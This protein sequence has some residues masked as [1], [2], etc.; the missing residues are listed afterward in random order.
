MPRFAPFWLAHYKEIG[1]CCMTEPLKKLKAHDN[2][3][4]AIPEKFQS[5]QLVVDYID[6]NWM[7]G[8]G[9]KWIG[10][11]VQGYYAWTDPN[12]MLYRISDLQRNE[13]GKEYEKDVEEVEAYGDPRELQ[14]NP[15]AKD[16]YTFERDMQKNCGFCPGGGGSSD[17]DIQEKEGT[18]KKNI[19]DEINLDELMKGQMN[20]FIPDDGSYVP[21]PMEY[22]PV[23]DST[24]ITETGHVTGEIFGSFGGD[25]YTPIIDEFLPG[26]PNQGNGTDDGSAIEK[27]AIYP[28]PYLP[29]KP[30]PTPTPN[31]TP[32]GKRGLPDLPKN[33]T[34]TRP[35]VKIDPAIYLPP[36]AVAGNPP[37]VGTYPVTPTG[38]KPPLPP[39]KLATIPKIIPPK[40]PTQSIPKAGNNK[41]AERVKEAEEM[42]KNDT[43]TYGRGKGKIDC[44]GATDEISKKVKDGAFDKMK[45]NPNFAPSLAANQAE[46]LKETGEFTTNINNV[47]EGDYIFWTKDDHPTIQKIGHTGIVTSIVNGKITVATAEQANLTDKSFRLTVLAEDGTIW[48]KRSGTGG[49]KFV[50]AGRP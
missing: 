27:V 33:P 15:T 46:H 16:L 23:T 49:Q 40:K 10:W 43:R 28:I 18:K 1:N 45:Y 3:K 34:D 24:E 44:S 25:S 20:G 38:R 47:K 13:E 37:S 22:V 29:P 21:K 17:D 6:T 42:V 41:A 26:S 32:P 2:E 14:G 12:G 35:A 5:L 8:K 30:L 36:K 11:D 19:A 31:P 7:S 48:R 9:L 50:G 39:I 4:V